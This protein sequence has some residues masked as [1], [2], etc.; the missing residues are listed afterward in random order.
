MTKTPLRLAD[1]R[2]DADRLG[3]PPA[4][5]TNGFILQGSTR[6][7]NDYSLLALV[8]CKRFLTEDGAT[9]IVEGSSNL[10]TN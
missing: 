7:D 6:F 10:T 9:L 1:G 2:N 8:S 5:C 3:L 4:A